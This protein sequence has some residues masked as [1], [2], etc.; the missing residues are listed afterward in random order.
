MNIKLTLIVFLGY[1]LV[2]TIIV[3]LHKYF[4]D[5]SYK[6]FVKKEKMRMNEYLKQMYIN[7]L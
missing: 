3:L 5:R 7:S 4:F 6:N 1:V 2:S